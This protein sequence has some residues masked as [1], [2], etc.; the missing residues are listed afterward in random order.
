MARFGA[1]TS[2]DVT[3]PGA[4]SQAAIDTSRAAFPGAGNPPQ[5]FVVQA[6]SLTTPANVAALKKAADALAAVPQ[7]SRATAPTARNGQLAATGSIGTINATLTV[8]GRDI[9][10][11]LATT[12]RDAVDQAV[13]GTDIVVTPADQLAQVLDQDNN[14]RAELFALVKEHPEISTL[15]L[16]SAPGNKPGPLVAAVTGKFAGKIGIPVTVI[17]ATSRTSQTNAAA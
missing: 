4:D 13:A 5:R 9:T 15:V 16:S 1:A 11:S 3:I 8:A 17:P 2:D 12:L 10:K 6:P 14:R 7:V